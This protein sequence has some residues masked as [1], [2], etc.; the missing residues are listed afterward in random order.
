MKKRGID[1]FKTKKT[2]SI[3]IGDAPAPLP[4]KPQV[5]SEINEMSVFFFKPLMIHFA[6]IMEGLLD[7]ATIFFEGKGEGRGVEK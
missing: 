5:R 7:V 1:A 4:S 3:D 6:L 2:L